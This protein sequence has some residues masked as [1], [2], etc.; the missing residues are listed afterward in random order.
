MSFNFSFFCP[1]YRVPCCLLLIP[2][3]CSS[4]GVFC[5]SRTPPYFIVVGGSALVKL[6]HAG[7]NPTRI[8][9]PRFFENLTRTQA[10]RATFVEGPVA[11]RIL[12]NHVRI[13]LQRTPIH[14][15]SSQRL[16]VKSLSHRHIQSV[17]IR[18]CINT[19][20]LCANTPKR[21]QFVVLRRFNLSV[22]LV[23]ERNLPLWMLGDRAPVTSSGPIKR[24]G[25]GF[26]SFQVV[27]AQT[28]MATTSLCSSRP[29]PPHPLFLCTYRRIP[30]IPPFPINT[31]KKRH[32]NRV[33]SGIESTALL[34]T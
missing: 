16:L 2:F 14:T 9:K 22:S 29:V 11:V 20:N 6:V 3:H 10:G 18:Y 31:R 13:Q 33:Q 28:T 23:W 24:W 30:L 32:R 7:R 8:D 5:F 25:W 1:C 19:E 26:H 21:L 12:A 27:K 17:Q 15:V 4:F 34:F